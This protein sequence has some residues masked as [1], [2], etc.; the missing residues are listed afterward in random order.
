MLRPL[1]SCELFGVDAAEARRVLLAAVKGPQRPGGGAGVPGAGHAGRAARAGGQ[2]AAAAGELCAGVGMSRRVI[3]G[4]PAA[5][6][7]W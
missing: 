2:W 3:R 1:V 5:M 7:C 4:S 6:G